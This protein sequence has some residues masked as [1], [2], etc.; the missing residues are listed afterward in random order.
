M[1]GEASV[2]V[3]MHFAFDEVARQLNV[4]DTLFN[5]TSEENILHYRYLANEMYILRNF[6]T[7]HFGNF[8]GPTVPHAMEL[9]RILAKIEPPPPKPKPEDPEIVKGRVKHYLREVFSQP[10]LVD[11]LTCTDNLCALHGIERSLASQYLIEVIREGGAH[12][13]GH[14]AYGKGKEPILEA[15]AGFGPMTKTRIIECLAKAFDV[16]SETMADEFCDA[17]NRTTRFK[18]R[19]VGGNIQVYQ[20]RQKNQFQKTKKELKNYKKKK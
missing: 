6:L 18:I 2:S 14:F 1:K 17:E 10:V 13:I 16:S 15:A 11:M 9:I 5:I 19:K 3:A 8:E 7:L 4:G 12:Q 20:P